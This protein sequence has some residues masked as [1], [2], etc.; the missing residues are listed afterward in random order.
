MPAIFKRPGVSFLYP[1]NWTVDV[2]YT[3]TDHQAVTVYSPSGG[4]WSV[5]LHNLS[6]EPLKLA[7]SALEAMRDE[8][9]GLEVEDVTASIADYDLIG[10]DM[11]FFHMDLTNTAQ[12]RSFKSNES[13]YTVFCQAEDSEFEENHRVF[14]AITLSLINGLKPS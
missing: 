14:D 5:A 6:V 9:Q 8:Y 13:T 11:H 3:S 4:F 1:E 10:F 2:E 12:I 7:V